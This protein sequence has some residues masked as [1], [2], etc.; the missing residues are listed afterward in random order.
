[1]PIE[2]PRAIAGYLASANA[3]DAE[4]CASWFTEDAIVHDEGQERQGR[5]AI[6]EW[7][8]EVSRKYRPVISPIHM[9]NAKE[10]I[11]VTAKVAGNFPG[12]P[13]E[14][15]F[16]FTLRGDGITRLDIAP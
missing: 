8:E 15:R 6:R 10:K 7:K 2:L 14:L 3:H 16:A 5:T 13:I 4:T 9:I 1:M 11:I 12:S